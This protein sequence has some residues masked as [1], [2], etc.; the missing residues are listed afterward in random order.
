[1]Y[2]EDAHLSSS[3]SVLK[4]LF[5]SFFPFRTPFRTREDM[6]SLRCM[7]CVFLVCLVAPV[8]SRSRMFSQSN[9][10]CQTA[11]PT[12][13]AAVKNPNKNKKMANELSTGKTIAVMAI[14]IGCFAI[15]WPMIFYPMLQ[16]AFNLNTPASST[17]RSLHERRGE[18]NNEMM[19]L[20]VL[21]TCSLIMI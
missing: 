6:A 7:L 11:F 17:R 16:A 4:M 9:V 20:H 15:L 10:V 12:T 5:S 3:S 8:I 19:L 14:V 21:T 13:S 2:D 18:I 1:M